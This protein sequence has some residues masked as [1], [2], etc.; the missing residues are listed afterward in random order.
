MAA[1]IE[2]ALTKPRPRARY[3]V[4]LDAH[5]VARLEPLIPPP[6]FDWVIAKT[7]RLPKPPTPIRSAAPILRPPD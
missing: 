5:V 7:M 1:R 3:L 2:V 6:I 4:G